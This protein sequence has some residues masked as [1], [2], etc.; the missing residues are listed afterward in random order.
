MKSHFLYVYYLGEKDEV[1]KAA[2]KS[3]NSVRTS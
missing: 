3:Q 2:I 1:R